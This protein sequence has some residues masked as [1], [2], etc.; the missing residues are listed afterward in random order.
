MRKICLKEKW[1]KKKKKKNMT[2]AAVV[3][4]ISKNIKSW[5]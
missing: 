2:E 3:N 1:L 4:R 5:K